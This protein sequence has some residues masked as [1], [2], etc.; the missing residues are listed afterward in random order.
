M[1]PLKAELSAI[2]SELE[3]LSADVSRVRQLPRLLL[4]PEEAAEVLSISRSS[5]YELVQDGEISAIHVGRNL[6]LPM[7]EIEAYVQRKIEEERILQ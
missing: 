3:R 4:S 2:R 7:A 1:P 5:V 6:K